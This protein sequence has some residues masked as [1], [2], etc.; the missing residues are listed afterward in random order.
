MVDAYFMSNGE[1]P[2]S[3]YSADGVTPIINEKSDYVE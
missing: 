2:I 3:G 1:S